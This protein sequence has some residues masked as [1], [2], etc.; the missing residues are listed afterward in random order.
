MLTTCAQYGLCVPAKICKR[1]RRR[2]RRRL[3]L[4]PR[5]RANAVL[6]AICYRGCFRV[7]RLFI[8]GF[9][10]RLDGI[11]HR[12]FP[13]VD[14]STDCATALFCCS[15]RPDL[16]SRSHTRRECRRATLLPNIRT[17]SLGFSGHF[18]SRSTRLRR[19]LTLFVLCVYVYV[20]GFFGIIE[21]PKSCKH[22]RL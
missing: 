11:R 6:S 22:A 4:W 18:Q 20:L 2:E 15:E 16:C 1:V 19:V 17:T 5:A 7:P 9:D 14:F 13:K 21:R 10:T 8:N 3:R 12:R